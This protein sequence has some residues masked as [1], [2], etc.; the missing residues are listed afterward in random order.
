[1]KKY[2]KT[3]FYDK[4]GNAKL[5][6]L[7]SGWFYA[8]LLLKIILGCTL[9]SSYLTSYFAP[10]I[11][12]FV[13][14]GFN[15][16]Y[17]YF[18][19][20]STGAEF[21]YP[22]LMLWIMA[23]PRVIFSAFADNQFIQL[24]IYRLPLLVMDFAILT[25]LLRWIKTNHKKVIIYYW[26]SPII[27][28][29]NYIHGQLDIIPIGFLVI[30]LYFLFKR[31]WTV[32]AFFIACSIGTKTNMA[33]VVPFIAIYLIKLNQLNLK[34]Y[35]KVSLI[36]IL[37]LL[38]INL[39]YLNSADFMTMVYHNP[40]Q[41]KIFESYF[42]FGSLSYIFIP[43][44]YLMLLLRL[45]SFRSVNKDLLMLFLAFSFGTIILF[46]PPMQ[47]WYCWTIP[48]FIYF[49]VKQDMEQ[50]VIFVLLN[51]F[52]F[53]FFAV[54]PVSDFYSVF[55][56]FSEAAVF[57]TPYEYFHLS[58]N[59]VN[60]AFTFMQTALAAF[61]IALYLK[62]I[63]QH[64]GLKMLYKPFLIGVGGDSGA[65]KSTFTALSEK[66]FGT[67]ITSIIRGDDMHKWERGNEN[68]KHVTHLNPKAND[69]HKD[70]SDIKKLKEGYSVLR[71]H[72]N[73]DN[74]NF[75]LPFEIKSNKL[76]MFEG[77]HPFYL[78]N[79]AALYDLKVFIRPD[80]SIRIEQKLARDTGERGKTSEGVI[81]QINDRQEDSDKYIKAQE[82]NADVIF[83]FIPAEN[84]RALMVTLANDIPLDNLILQLSENGN[85][86]ITHEFSDDDKQVLILKGEISDTAIELI[87]FDEAP[88]LEDL[89]IY[90]SEWEN[91]YNGIMQLIL[92]E[93]V[94][95]KM[96]LD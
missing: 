12:Y 69:I 51:V 4:Y 7:N 24:F 3:I 29:I 10:F 41:Q 85:L 38:I 21:P 63:R 6:G 37:T 25:V 30:C 82:K 64:T 72:Y 9:A 55:Y 15:D 90:Q 87:A 48:F 53:F 76:V 8:G 18:Q 56:L 93:A 75:S 58:Q 59:V 54:T 31:N 42:S 65:G 19:Q 83:S 88:W 13:E 78:K 16:P 94:Y 11:N 22:P 91:N 45:Q 71:K 35:I 43:G 2:Y 40:V 28:Y 33:I 57:I 77:L 61:L 84:E 74:G 86:D 50:P 80:E 46:V 60:V 47:G 52:Y 49:M 70:F 79:Q 81:N 23:T 17:A 39:P 27:I 89:G 92:L 73:H 5:R 68:W 95:Y 1:M 36:F 34:D 44:V 26:L 62:G 66:V 32:A 96:K 20:N 67:D 14:S